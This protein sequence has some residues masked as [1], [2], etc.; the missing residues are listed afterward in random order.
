M[1][2]LAKDRK[3]RSSSQPSPRGG[4]PSASRRAMLGGHPETRALST[5]TRRPRSESGSPRQPMSPSNR[6]P[7]AR[8]HESRASHWREKG[9]VKDAAFGQ[10][11]PNPGAHT[12]L[13]CRP[14]AARAAGV[15]SRADLSWLSLKKESEKNTDVEKQ[16]GKL[17][18]GRART[19]G[20]PTG[21]RALGWRTLPLSWVR[22][23]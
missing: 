4:F 3:K 14:G 19:A 23:H 17:G 2:A 16:H 21:R 1:T 15:W 13:L 8:A 12:P 22:A 10:S 9:Q 7:P 6:G 18:E 20:S 11:R 5:G